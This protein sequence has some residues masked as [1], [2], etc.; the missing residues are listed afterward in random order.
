MRTKQA[1]ECASKTRS[2]QPSHP[3]P[4]LQILRLSL[5]E[6]KLSQISDLRCGVMF[7]DLFVLLRDV[8]D[9]SI[10]LA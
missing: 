1:A 8:L 6:N 10:L 2:V 5:Q 3:N 7:W 4:T 9:I